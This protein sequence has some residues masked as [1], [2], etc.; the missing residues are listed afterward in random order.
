MR[1][2]LRRAIGIAMTAAY[3]LLAAAG[4][5][6]A[7]PKDVAGHWSQPAVKNLMRQGVLLG[8]PDH[9]FKPDRFVSRAEFAR[10]VAKAF[11]LESA[12]K[13]PFSDTAGHW[14]RK[15]VAALVEKG[16]IDGYPDGTFRPDTSITRAEMV[17]MLDRLLQVGVKEQVFGYDWTPSYPDVPKDHWAFRLVEVARRLD[18]L[19]PTYGSSF[20]PGAVVTRAET[21]WMVDQVQSLGK[22][23]GTAIEIDADAGTLTVLP[24]EAGDPLS[25][26]LD[27]EAL[28]LRNNSAVTADQIVADDKLVALVGRDGLA[29]V[30]RASGEI[31]R[32]DLASRL[33]GLTK[34]ILTPDTARSLV[35]GDWSAAQEALKGVLFDRLIQMG[36]GPGEAQSLLDRD[37]MTLD[38]LS[39]DRLITALSSR[40]GLSTDLSE[41]LLSQ[42][43]SRIKSALQSE[44]TALALGRFL[45]GGQS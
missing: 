6:R 19:P 37:W 4:A 25:L 21:A 34:G 44:I 23:Q 1:V 28:I 22:Q 17:A 41:A 3:L 20:L 40:L 32:N 8:Y 26:Q 42:D 35:A 7:V 10:I 13:A 33:S 30:V 36:L 16:I 18:Y 43:F 9:T 45:Q 12:K 14:A 29:K 27:P 5:A 31:N 39:R 11:K 2:T 38:L 24:E 15:E